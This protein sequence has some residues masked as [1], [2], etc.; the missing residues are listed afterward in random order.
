[1]CSILLGSGAAAAP[2]SR[3]LGGGNPMRRPVKTMQNMSEV[4]G[5]GSP[6]LEVPGGRK[7]PEET[8]ENHTTSD[9]RLWGGGSL[10]PMRGALG[11]GGKGR[12]SAP[13]RNPAKISA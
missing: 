10:P 7:H 13:K 9:R 1:M 8:D 2:H 6:Q 12:G 3:S 11:E 4:W 5:G